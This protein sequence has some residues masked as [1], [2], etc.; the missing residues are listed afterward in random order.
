[1]DELASVLGIEA[2]L[3]VQVLRD[4]HAIFNNGEQF[5]RGIPS[6]D[7]H[8]LSN[9][10]KRRFGCEPHD[11]ARIATWFGRLGRLVEERDRAVQ[12]KLTMMVWRSVC[13]YGG[14]PELHHHLELDGQQFDARTGLQTMHGY[15]FPGA[16][17]GCRCLSKSI[18]PGW[19]D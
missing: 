9:A 17:V 7:L 4:Y 2:H 6:G 18:I 11:A 16:L 12:L 19:D 1:M 10:A 15:L 5:A 8:A 14:P 3:A 13:Q